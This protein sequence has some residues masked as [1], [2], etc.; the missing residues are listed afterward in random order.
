M[1][2]DKTRVAA[3]GMTAVVWVSILGLVLVQTV[4]SGVGLRRHFTITTVLVSSTPTITSNESSSLSLLFS[5]EEEDRP[6]PD[7]GGRIKNTTTFRTAT[8]T[9]DA[10]NTTRS[11]S[12]NSQTKRFHLTSD[13]A[14]LVELLNSKERRVGA[15]DEVIIPLLQNLRKNSTTDS[16]IQSSTPQGV[17]NLHI[18]FV[19]DSVVRYLFNS[20]ALFLHTGLW[21]AT[22]RKNAS[23]TYQQHHRGWNGLFRYV[24]DHLAPY[25]QCDCCRKLRKN[26]QPS[27]I[28]ENHYYFDPSR[29]LSLTFIGRCVIVFDGYDVSFVCI[30][31]YRW[32]RQ[33]HAAAHFTVMVDDIDIYRF[34]MQLSHGHWLTRNQTH[35]KHELPEQANTS[36]AWEYNTTWEIL[37]Q[38]LGPHLNVDFVVMSQGNWVDHD[39]RLDAFPQHLQQVQQALR[40]H[41]MKGLYWKYP[42]RHGDH[43]SAYCE[44]LDGCIDSEAWLESYEKKKSLTVD[45]VH[46]RPYMYTG[47]GLELLDKVASMTV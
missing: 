38:V 7:H 14:A 42:V 8:A 32:N 3:R 2:E 39:F 23:I 4:H 20:V 11:S 47:F 26:T 9:L 13:E 17:R 1:K 45:S 10:L 37:D 43:Q 44:G 46:F 19:G 22:N 41:G 29:N 12:T 15:L 6:A 36:Y 21:D 30:S 16:F 18:A 31:A 35:Q 24:H 33:T 34:G 5:T 25:E 28:Y 27:E 40:K